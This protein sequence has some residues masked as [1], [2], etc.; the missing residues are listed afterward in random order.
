L[1][2]VGKLTARQ[3]DSI[4]GLTFCS[5]VLGAGF[6]LWVNFG[7]KYVVAVAGALLSSEFLHIGNALS[8]NPDKVFHASEILIRN[9]KFEKTIG[10]S[11]KIFE[12]SVAQ[13]GPRLL[14]IQ[15]LCTNSVHTQ[16]I[17]HTINATWQSDIC[18]VIRHAPI[19]LASRMSTCVDQ[20]EAESLSCV[21]IDYYRSSD[22]ADIKV[23]GSWRSVAVALQLFR[24]MSLE[25]KTLPP[26]EESDVES[27]ASV[28]EPKNNSGL[29]NS[30]HVET[31][32]GWTSV[33]QS[34]LTNNAD[35]RGHLGGKNYVAAKIGEK[36]V[37]RA[38]LGWLFPSCYALSTSGSITDMCLIKL[39]RS[40]QL[41]VLS[42]M[43][44]NVLDTDRP[45]SVLAKRN[46]STETTGRER[47][48]PVSVQ[49]W[50]PEKIVEKEIK[51]LKRSKTK[52]S[53]SSTWNIEIGFAPAALREMQL[54]CRLHGVVSSPSGHPNIVLPIGVA[55]P[56]PDENSSQSTNLIWNDTGSSQNDAVSSLFRSNGDQQKTERRSKKV[57]GSPSLVFNAGPFTLNRILARK[58]TKSLSEKIM[59][60]WFDDCIS[61]LVHCHSNNV[62]IGSLQPDQIHIDQSGALKLGY[63]YRCRSVVDECFA[64]EKFDYSKVSRGSRKRDELEDYTNDFYAAPEI[65]L[66]SPEYTKQSDVWAVGSLLANLL[67]NR[68]VCS[69]KD[70]HS[71]LTS[72]YKIVGVPT[73]SNFPEAMKLPNYVKP[74][75]KYVSDVSKALK[76][77][78]KDDDD[79]YSQHIQLICQMLQLDPRNR[80]TAEEAIQ[81]QLIIQNRENSKN[82]SY[83]EEYASDWLAFKRRM[84]SVKDGDERRYD[85]KR[86][87]KRNTTSSSLDKDDLYDIDELVEAATKKTKTEK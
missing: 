28:F 46:A 48:I 74:L 82:Q 26:F 2:R 52:T 63:L 40:E 5:Q 47:F 41:S 11:H 13:L 53:D 61:F 12:G 43:A 34:V 35:I 10:V 60:S 83:R 44:A 39:K 76:K 73:R 78:L 25:G 16:P 18:G 20:I 6:E 69:G 84:M 21:Y 87:A 86:S 57:K 27:S 45:H 54:L 7:V 71:F 49:R 32:A 77:L 66:G 75:K 8:L 50:P 81:C 14:A 31:A 85:D 33:L 72:Q 22:T 38:G 58:A 59:L 64:T 79:V 23:K 37:S 3:I 30:E 1:I 80:C 17:A 51:K 55:I 68:P 36:S 15:Q 29:L 9:S 62:V 19:E 67:L 56:V 65:L 4:F 42:A 70:R 24:E